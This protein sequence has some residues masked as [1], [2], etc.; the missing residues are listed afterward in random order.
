MACRL[1]EVKYNG[2]ELEVLYD[3]WAGY[4][5]KRDSMGAPEE[6]DEKPGLDVVDVCAG[7]ISI[8]DI[9]EPS[10]IEKIEG[11]IKEALN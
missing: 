5:G 10:Q 4:K 7:S 1:I 8:T 3:F 11:L 2:V 9:L 6:E